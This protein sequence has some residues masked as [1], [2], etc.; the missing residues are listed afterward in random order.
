M[1][2]EKKVARAAMTKKKFSQIQESLKNNEIDDDKIS[3]IME[4]IK[5]IMNFDPTLPSKT[6]EEKEKIR[7]H[8]DKLKSDGVSMYEYSGRKKQYAKELAKNAS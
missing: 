7:K 8:L 6:A 4:D 3:K 5:T 2:A 1:S